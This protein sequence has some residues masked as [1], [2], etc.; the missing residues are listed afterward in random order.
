MK[1]IQLSD[2]PE[3]DKSVVKIDRTG[4]YSKY[5]MEVTPVKFSPEVIPVDVMSG[6]ERLKIS[7][8]NV[9][10]SNQLFNKL[11]IRSESGQ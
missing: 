8:D 6:S 10:P 1:I 3:L 5:E 2:Y 4:N 11:F 7:V 9:N